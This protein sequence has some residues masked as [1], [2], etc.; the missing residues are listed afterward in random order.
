MVRK[1]VI[2]Y[3]LF[4]CALVSIVL[5]MVF[6]PI[7]KDVIVTVESGIGLLSIINLLIYA[8]LHKNHTGHI[9]SIATLF[10]IFMY[11]FNLGIPISRLLGWISESEERFLERRIYSM[12]AETFAEYLGY[13]FSLISFLQVGLYNYI[14]QRGK[15]EYLENVQNCD[16][17]AARSVST[18]LM[19]MGIVPYAYQEFATIRNAIKYV[20]Q[21]RNTDFSLAGTGIGLLAGLFMI[22][23]IMRMIAYQEQKHK[24]DAMFF[25][26][27][28]YQAIRMY[29]T[30]DRSTGVAL[31]LV[32]LLMRH[33]FV[34][35]IRRIHGLIYACGAYAAMLML[36]VIEITR[37][38]D[39]YVLTDMIQTVSQN[40]ALAE[41]VNEYGGNVWCGMM[42]Y[43]AVPAT[44][45]FRCGLTY[46]AAIVGKPLQILGFSNEVWKFADFSYF[47]QDEA[48]GT[49]INS[50]T[51]AMGGSFSGEWYYNFGWI[52]ILLIPIFGHYLG[53]FSDGCVNK[54]A[55]PV[56]AAF[57]LYTAT[58]V[59][60][61]VRQ[62]F[63]SVSWATMF[64]GV[65][66]WIV[67]SIVHRRMN[68]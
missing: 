22:G 27:F 25:I 64:G 16:F 43:Y 32:M 50:L 37:S 67:Y 41:T 13:V 53:K 19:G 52:G 24:F 65:V 66:T 42:V 45:G 48:R 21:E 51:A 68:G 18:I 30:G 36:K 26:M 44:G 35:P 55:N 38:I 59:L 56:V 31:I 60:W 8:F 57:L 17:N 33:E 12:G 23:Y 62:Y 49:L 10:L 28:A 4:E 29:V 61:W 2:Q 20:Y 6:Q 39:N 14:T 11:L 3:F 1:S 46:L 63:T 15:E 54:K 9:I 40:N 47:L 58:L 34:Q 5:F 7:E